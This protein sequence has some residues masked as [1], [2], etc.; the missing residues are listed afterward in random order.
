MIQNISKQK[1]IDIS[2]I[3]EIINEIS[4]IHTGKSV[5]LKAL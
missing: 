1:T 3:V 5:N 2:T 4:P